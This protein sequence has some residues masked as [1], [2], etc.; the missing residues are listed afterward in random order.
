MAY[1][2]VLVL[3]VY[4][5]ATA[6]TANHAVLTADI[7]IMLLAGALIFLVPIA[8]L[9]LGSGGLRSRPAHLH[10]HHSRLW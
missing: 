2:A 3:A 4:L 8:L 5:A 6:V 7:R 1:Q 10:H 9:P